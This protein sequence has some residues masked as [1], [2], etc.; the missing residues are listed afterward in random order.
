METYAVIFE[1]VAVT[2]DQDLMSIIA[3]DD[4]PCKVIY[5]ELGQVTELGDAAEEQLR[6]SI[7]R[8]NTTVGSGGSAF[9][10]TKLNPNAVA[11]GASAR[12]NDTTEASAGTAVHLYAGAWNIRS[13]FIWDATPERYIGVGGADYLCVRV[14]ASPSDSVTM[15][16]VM[17]FIEG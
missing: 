2:A 9:T 16:G 15:S 3:A 8:G 13:P 1:N 6:I 5:V 14:L 7:T 10:P 17:Y 4:R 12:I 11:A